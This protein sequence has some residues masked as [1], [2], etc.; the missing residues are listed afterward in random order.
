MVKSNQ[1]GEGIHPPELCSRWPDPTVFDQRSAEIGTA[2]SEMFIADAVGEGCDSDKSTVT[3]PCMQQDS[4]DPEKG[5]GSVK[6]F[7]E[8]NP[9]N[10][11][12]TLEWR[13]RVL[14]SQVATQ[15]ATSSPRQRPTAKERWQASVDS[16]MDRTVQ[17]YRAQEMNLQRAIA[18]LEQMREWDLKQ[19]EDGE[20]YYVPG[21]GEVESDYQPTE[22]GNE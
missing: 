5:L 15:A 13:R 4:E 19:L 3:T 16:E 14:H 1:T 18:N 17:H 7:I 21:W 22:Y 10:M 20:D 6:P 12:S 8:R 9:D 2:D 11:A